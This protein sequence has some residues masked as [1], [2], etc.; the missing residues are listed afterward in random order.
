M[1]KLICLF[2]AL[3]LLTACGKP[4]ESAT[5]AA[6]TTTVPV[7]T[8]RTC[9]VVGEQVTFEPWE[10]DGIPTEGSYCLTRD[11]ELTATVEITGELK[12]HLNGHKI[13]AKAGEILGHMFRIPAGTSMTKRAL[14][15]GRRRSSTIRRRPSISSGSTSRSWMKAM[16][17]I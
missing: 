5:T 11:V 2:L 16:T 4:A 10:Q 15:A 3:L 1:K 13:T 9:E 14:P 12:L 7:P 8:A 17:R 6:P